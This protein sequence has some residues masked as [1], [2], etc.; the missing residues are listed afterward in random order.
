MA[1]VNLA[2]RVS[3]AVRDILVTPVHVNGDEESRAE[4]VALPSR[5]PRPLKLGSGPGPKGGTSWYPPSS[6]VAQG[7][8]PRTELGGCR[9]A[10]LLINPTPQTACCR[11][12]IVAECVAPPL[13]G[14]TALLTAELDMTLDSRIKVQPKNR[15][16]G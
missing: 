2:E 4:F 13:H 16:R 3:F 15:I 14:D 7:A 9:R 11:L 8:S 10:G 1:W 12:D 6:C 5:V